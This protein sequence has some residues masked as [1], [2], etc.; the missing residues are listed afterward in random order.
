LDVTLKINQ[1]NVQAIIATLNR[2]DYEVKATF[3]E[4]EYLDGLKERF[5][6]LMMYLNV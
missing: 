3:N 6:G 5:D 4:G 2:F 1:Q